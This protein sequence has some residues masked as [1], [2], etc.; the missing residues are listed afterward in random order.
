MFSRVRTVPQKRDYTNAKKSGGGGRDGKNG[1]DFVGGSN[2]KESSRWTRHIR[3]NTV[4]TPD[5]GLDMSVGRETE[6]LR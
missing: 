2:Y 4:R 6:N 5:G 3:D 1:T